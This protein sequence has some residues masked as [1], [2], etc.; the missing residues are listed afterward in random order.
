MASNKKSITGLM[1]MQHEVRRVDSMF[2]KNK[3]SSY[4]LEDY[5]LDWTFWS[6]DRVELPVSSFNS[7]FT[8]EATKHGIVV[9]DINTK[10]ENF[11]LNSRVKLLSEEI[12]LLGGNA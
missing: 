6:S 12:T 4:Y 3:G 8:Q 5:G 2:S 10:I 9:L 7:Y 1:N 11:A